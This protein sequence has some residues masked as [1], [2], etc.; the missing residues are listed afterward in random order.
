MASIGTATS[1]FALSDGLAPATWAVRDRAADDRV[2]DRLGDRRAHGSVLIRGGQ[3]LSAG[4]GA[5]YLPGDVLLRGRTITEV[6][7]DLSM[8][9]QDAG[10]VVVDAGDSLVLPGF[11]DSHVHAWEGQLRG[12]A[13]AVDLPRYMQLTH[14]GLALHYRPHDV[15]VGTLLT[16]LLELD[17]GVTTLV[18][19]S[20]V[21][22][23]PEHSD[24]AVE[25]L[26]DS[27]IRGVHASGPAQAGPTAGQW[28]ADVL[29][30]RDQ[31]FASDD[32]LL[33]LRLFDAYPHADLWRFARDHELWISH[34]MGG[35][36]YVENL[37]D[38]QQAGLLDHR[39]TFNH[40]FGTAPRDLRLIADAGAQ[41][42]LCARSDASFGLGPS[43]PPVDEVLAAGLHPGLSMDNELS[44]GLDM[45][46]E[47]QTLLL[48]HRAA[49][50]R[51]ATAGG[52]HQHL[53][54][55]QV[56]GFATQGG[57]DNAGL[58]AVTGSVTAG[59][60]ADIVLV[61][62]AALNTCL[63]GTAGPVGFA[64]RS[65]AHTVFVAGRPRKWRGRLLDVDVP[66]LLGAAAASRAY[67]LAAA[68]RTAA[69]GLQAAPAPAR[70]S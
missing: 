12:L 65:N 63:T 36:G 11:V 34:E 14:H 3:L 13:P 7:P 58:G 68:G 33:T 21:A 64:N 2:L 1:R 18:D 45:F 35:G 39:H 24:A 22:R 6:G 69:A 49:T 44:Y 41:V 31:Y 25:A 15:Y 23:T 28:P 37:P 66:A 51:A 43:Q 17:G 60:Q 53:T 10:C 56:L 9:A 57:A 55:E 54:P 8:H 30:L 4:H 47:M 62:T 16:A 70:A 40:C 26:R 5:G 19:N 38:L 27:G 42:N 32:Q 46:V 59:K 48:S 50:F 20:N 52:T 29:R 61:D 67:L